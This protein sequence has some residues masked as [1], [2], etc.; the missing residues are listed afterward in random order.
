MKAERQ[1]P[2]AHP[3]RV[4]ML[5]KGWFPAQLGGLDR[6]YRDLLE[7][8]P[9]AVGVVVG[10][11]PGA[12][13]SVL[14][15]S[16]HDEPLPRRMLA[17][18]RATQRAHVQGVDVIDAH[19]ALYALLPLL[20]GR[21]RRVPTVVHFQGPWAHE[22]VSA[23]DASSWRLVARRRLEREVYRRADAT[24][25]LTSA[26][27]RTLV[28]HYRVAPWNV[29]V[30]APGV[31]LD[32][33][34]TG[35]RTGA[36]GRFE[37]ADGEWLAVCV[38]RLIGRMGLEHLLEAWAA[39]RSELPVGSRLLIAG[40]GPMR[41]ELEHRAQAPD[42]IG[43]VRLLGRIS[44]DDL[45]ELYRA[46][47]LGVVPTTSFE[48]FGLV[49][50][51]AAAC[52]TPTL[53]TSVGGLPEVVGPLDPTLLVPGGDQQALADRIV[54]ASAGCVPE[55]RAT[56]SYAER[57]DWREVARKHRTIYS[58]VLNRTSDQRLKVVYL[59][60]VGELSGGELALLR[61]LPHLDE[62]N[63]HVILA[64]DGLF[65]DRLVEAG[66]SVEVLP[67][68]GA[69]RQLRKDAIRPGQVPARAA[70]DTIAYVARLSARLR[71]LRP[72]LVHTN[73]LKAGVYGSLAARAAGVPVVW[74]VRDRL[75]RD[76]LPGPAIRLIGGMMRHLTV[77]V[78]TNSRATSSTLDLPRAPVVVHSPLGAALP[79][80]SDRDPRD[81]ESCTFGM[82]GRIAA[83][84][85]QDLFIRA[86]A[87]AFPAGSERAV[88]V[89]SP[90]FG[91]KAVEDGLR[92]L[93]ATLDIE[94]RVDFRGF[95]ENVW[96]ELQ[97]IDVL[98]HASTTPEPH[99]QVVVEGMAAGLPV[100]VP[101]EGGPAEI[102]TD[103][104]TGRVFVARDVVSL[105][106][107]LVELR[108]SPETRA[109]LGM[110]ARD[111][112]EPFQPSNVATTLQSVYRDVLSR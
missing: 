54:A 58:R 29:E 101:N 46:A 78:V 13:P 20:I 84:K 62:V 59:D 18:W 94:D 7:H 67:L 108:A 38:R 43:S 110:M 44:D 1:S 36:R 11:A 63:P 80:M 66:I 103:G 19:F 40:D 90:M 111:A 87:R 31:D 30:L 99:G 52:G 16:R 32:R 74:H 6:Y 81:V 48:G 98:V 23:G 70:F 57:F 22:N 5:G 47:D 95:R 10:P 96:A 82:V 71:T 42:L 45:V 112:V 56:R 4:L 91:E 68:R 89:G 2:E 34:S 65:A 14:A 39:A 21:L 33:F 37:C 88:I 77:G 73:S 26:F 104:V 105:S 49:V 28:E 17:F 85:G 72:D 79:R 102:V 107:V 97:A 83:W 93:V 50:I 9:E 41:E 27:R 35:D 15:A 3:A 100:V 64:E 25:V 76:Y 51:E 106:Q 61:L 109:R 69:T 86:F 24:V 75:T 92:K 12:P 53:A 8:L 60:H 55:R